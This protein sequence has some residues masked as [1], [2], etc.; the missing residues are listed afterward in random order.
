MGDLSGSQRA[1]FWIGLAI[2]QV[3]FGLTVFGVSRLYYLGQ[4][5]PVSTAGSLDFDSIRFPTA[6]ARA[7]QGSIEPLPES[8]TSP[9]TPEAIAQRADQQFQARNYAEAAP[10]YTRLVELDPANVT[11]LNNLAITLHYLGRSDEAI[12][13]LNT[14]LGIDAE[15]QRSW[16]TLGFINSQTG[17]FEAA[18]TALTHAIELGPDNNVGESAANMLAE[19]GFEAPPD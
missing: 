17:N 5:E 13:H 10:L 18:R 1:R 7:V 6:I 16:L 19:M 8:T 15:H 11:L 9:Q 12:Q 14:G 2:F 3:V 4:R